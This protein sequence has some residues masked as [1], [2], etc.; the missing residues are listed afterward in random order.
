MPD[1]GFGASV[2]QTGMNS[3]QLSL[4]IVANNLANLTTPGFEAAS[5]TVFSAQAV[6]RPP[7]IWAGS[8]AVTME[9]EAI[10]AG[11]AQAAPVLNLRPGALKETGQQTDWALTVPGYFPVQT[12]QGIRYTRNGAFTVSANGW[13]VTPSGDP[14]LGLNLKPIKVPAQFSVANGSLYTPQGTLIAKLAIAR[15]P[16]PLGMQS[17]GESLYALTP[18]SGPAR[19][20]PALG[21][22]VQQGFLEQSNTSLTRSLSDLIVDGTQFA[23]SAKALQ[24]SSTLAQLTG[25]MA[26]GL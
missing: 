3:A 17:V 26:S 20:L 6:A 18:E 11:V 1:Y 12:P 21:S 8:G 4:Q 10:M 2:A 5:P 24:Q 9:P 25:Q 16:N 23:L 15:V 19:Y 22:D 7:G 14:V 13:L